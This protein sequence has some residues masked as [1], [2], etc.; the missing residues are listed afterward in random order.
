IAVVEAKIE[1]HPL[2]GFVR[3]VSHETGLDRDEVENAARQ[4]FN[5]RTDLVAALNE[6]DLNGTTARMF[7][8]LHQHWPEVAARLFGAAAIIVG[9]SPSPTRTAASANKRSTERGEAEA[10]LIGALTMHHRYANGSCLNQEPVGCNVLARHAHVADSTASGF[11]KTHF[12]GHAKY[13]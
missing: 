13:R 7:A 3:L 1:A 6:C 9:N 11:F 5:G 2:R 8:E 10:K 12:D 4:E